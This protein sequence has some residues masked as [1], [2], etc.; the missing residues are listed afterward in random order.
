LTSDNIRALSGFPTAGEGQIAGKDFLESTGITLASNKVTL[1]KGTKIAFAIPT[2]Y[3]LSLIESLSENESVGTA[4]VTKTTISVNTGEITTS[5]D[6]YTMNS[7]N[8]FK[9]IKIYK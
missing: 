2:G 8:S 7:G 1:D 4:G 3:N 9:L 6:V 5:Y